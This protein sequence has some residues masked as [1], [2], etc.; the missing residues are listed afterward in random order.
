[1]NE[2]I[3]GNGG[4]IVTGENWSSGRKTFPSV[5]LFNTKHTWTDVWLN[6]SLRYEK[7]AN[8]RLKTTIILNYFKD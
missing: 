5:T 6:P 3:W 8:E 2:R 1:M 4:M 7:P